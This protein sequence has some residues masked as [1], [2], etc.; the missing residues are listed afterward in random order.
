MQDNLINILD[1]Y[2]QVSFQQFQKDTKGN[3]ILVQEA[4]CN[5]FKQIFNNEFIEM[6]IGG[7]L[8]FS[9]V[10]VIIRNN[11]HHIHKTAINKYE[12]NVVLTYDDAEVKFIGHKKKGL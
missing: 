2:D 10:T 5:Q 4:V 3:N 6:T 1:E 9:P 11:P 8:L 12:E 7:D